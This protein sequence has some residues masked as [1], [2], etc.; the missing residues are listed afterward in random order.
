MRELHNVW[1]DI[2]K[3]VG[4][5]QGLRPE[6][7]RFAATLYQREPQYKL[8]SSKEADV[9][10]L[11]ERADNAANIRKVSQWL[12]KV[13]K[14]C[15]SMCSNPRLKVVTG[16][17]QVYLLGVAIELRGD[18][19]DKERQDLLTC[20]EKVSFRIY[21]MMDKH[22]STAKAPYVRLAWNVVNNK[23]ISV[24]EIDSRIKKIGRKFPIK[25]AVKNLRDKDCYWKG[26]WREAL[27]YIMCRYEEHLTKEAEEA[28]ERIADDHREKIWREEMSI[29]HITP[30]SRASDDTVHRLG[31][32]ML[33]PPGLNS[34][35][36]NKPP[37]EKFGEYHA[38]GLLT[39]Q[40][41]AAR[42]KTKTWG[43]KDIQWRQNKILRW[44][45]QEWGD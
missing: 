32:L 31:N 40:E 37:E 35:L 10:A 3:E 39:A 29:E 19:S 43:P 21:F 30:Q 28:G 6:A 24:E 9:E 1:R 5:E 23:H 14:A 42:A 44:A 34:S 36:K 38:T 18:M 15:Q 25:D 26:D 16:I 11:R 13:A 12:L 45:E 33:L 22:W 20:W 4:L 17:Q 2:C 27:T 41:V 7:L 8:L